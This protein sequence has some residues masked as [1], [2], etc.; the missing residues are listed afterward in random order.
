MTDALRLVKV[1]NQAASS[2]ASPNMLLLQA[3]LPGKPL[4]HPRRTLDQY[5]Y[6][7]FDTSARDRDQ[8]VYRYCESHGH[9]RKIFMVDQL[10]LFV[11]GKGNCFSSVCDACFVVVWLIDLTSYR[12]C[13]YLLSRTV[14]A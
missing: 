1:A 9:Q 5:F 3:Y 14:G 8:V 11:L 10:W 13:C 12:P 6:Q 7:A 4:I 2:S